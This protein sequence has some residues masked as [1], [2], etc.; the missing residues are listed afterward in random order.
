MSNELIVYAPKDPN[1]DYDYVA[2]SFNGK[3][4]YDDFGIYRVSDGA[5]YNLPLIPELTDKTADITGA[6]GQFYFATYHKKR[7][8][9]INFAFDRMTEKT[10]REFKAWLNGKEL[11]PLWFAENPYKVYYAKVTGQPSFSALPFEDKELK[12]VYKGTGSIQFT[13]YYPYACTP[14]KV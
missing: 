2:F 11:A 10:L 12:R 5:R 9:T 14:D 6:D 8:F 13:C 1:F 7:T 4:S 3:N